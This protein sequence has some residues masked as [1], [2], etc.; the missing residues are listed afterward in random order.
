MK[1]RILTY[2]LVLALVLSGI[3]SVGYAAEELGFAVRVSPDPVGIGKETVVTVSLTG[4]TAQV[5]GIRGLQVDITGLDTNVLT[6]KEYTS[7]IQD[8]GALSNKASYSAK[9]NRVRLLY[10]LMQ[11]TLEAPCQDVL[12][13]VVQIN[14]ELTGEG[15]IDL[16]VKMLVQ[17]EDGQKLTLNASCTI[18]YAENVLPAV[19]VDI[20]WGAMEF[21]YTDGDW[22]PTTHSYAEGTWTDNG[23]GFVTVTN[24]GTEG[25]K[26]SFLYDT[27]RQDITGSFLDAEELPVT[28]MD[29]E[30]EDTAT[31]YLRLSGRPAEELDK[32]NLGTVTVRIGDE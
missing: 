29:L 19:S 28:Q 9:S 31:V 18:S 27:D 21:E 22:N 20:T 24:L 13:M 16:P 6:V 14:P 8:T 1:R 12:R 4:Y 7:L 26:A 11:G 10:A 3:T 17:T 32:T 5:S 15:S 2:I 30:S 25:T 23:T